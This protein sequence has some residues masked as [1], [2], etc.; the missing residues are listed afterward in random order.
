LKYLARKSAEIEIVS[1]KLLAKLF[2]LPKSD[3]IADENGNYE[4]VKEITDH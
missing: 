1:N 4:R 2:F 3:S